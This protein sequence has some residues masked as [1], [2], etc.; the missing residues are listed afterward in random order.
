MKKVK[1][2]RKADGKAIN[3]FDYEVAGLKGKIT[4]KPIKKEEKATGYTKER[5]TSKT[6][7]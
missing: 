2:Y 5:K 4:E 7:K 3:I 6:T 1:V